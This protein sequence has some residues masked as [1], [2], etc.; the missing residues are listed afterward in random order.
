MPEYIERDKIVADIDR[1]FCTVV[2]INVFECYGQVRGKLLRAPAADV[3]PVRHGR[4][5]YLATRGAYFCS[6]CKGVE[7]DA[8]S[9]YCPHC[10][11][12]M[13]AKGES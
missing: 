12:K 7:D 6:E 2:S 13:D 3:E 1:L 9:P 11:A 10:G 5:I 4:W 8:L